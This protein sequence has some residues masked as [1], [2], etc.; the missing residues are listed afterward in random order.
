MSDGSLEI[1]IKKYVIRAVSR[2]QFNELANAGAINKNLAGNQKA[3]SKNHYIAHTHLDT[4]NKKR[5][6]NKT[7]IKNTENN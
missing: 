1:F 5:G 6:I 7:L 4:I 2:K 3:H